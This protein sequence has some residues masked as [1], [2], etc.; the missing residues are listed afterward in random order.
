MNKP[1]ISAL[2]T[3]LLLAP[4]AFAELGQ[5]DPASLAPSF[6]AE[7][8]RKAVFCIRENGRKQ[9]DQTCAT[10][11]VIDASG[12]VVTAAHV[13]SGKGK[14]DFEMA[15]G[16]GK[17]FHLEIV[18]ISPAYNPNGGFL[19][20][21]QKMMMDE[22]KSR[23][24][25]QPF[26]QS[27]IY[28]EILP[29][30]FDQVDI[31]LLRVIPDDLA[32][33]QAAGVKPLAIRFLSKPVAGDRLFLAGFTWTHYADAYLNSISQVLDPSGSNPLKNTDGG[34]SV[35][36]GRYSAQRGK[37]LITRASPDQEAG[38]DMGTDAIDSFSGSSGAPVLDDQGRLVGIHSAS[39]SSL[40]Q[41]QMIRKSMVEL[42]TSAEF[43][44]DGLNSAKSVK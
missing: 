33:F 26:K 43:L 21:P 22:A 2:F 44:M 28:D 8:V 3:L 34:Y 29:S 19:R 9:F 37:I 41:F 23:F 17:I 30:V 4:P 10:A 38:T 15:D 35:L 11:S 25:G 7:D 13:V 39:D 6:P 16:Q 14:R 18:W 20:D 27:P 40:G 42:S 31:A 12:I 5:V 36:S 24:S 1:S 32:G